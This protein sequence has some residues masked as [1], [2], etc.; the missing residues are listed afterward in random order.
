[1]FS[2]E[3]PQSIPGLAAVLQVKSF[4]KGDSWSRGRPAAAQRAR[5]ALL[6]GERKA[7]TS[8]LAQPSRAGRNSRGEAQQ[9]RSPNASRRVLGSE[10]RP[11]TAVQG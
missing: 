2:V 5:G 10:S 7:S 11:M 8:Y 1:M 9:A 6:K 4:Q 3:L